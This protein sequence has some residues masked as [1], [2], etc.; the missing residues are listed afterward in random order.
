MPRLVKPAPDSRLD[1]LHGAL[2][3]ND[4]TDPVGRDIDLPGEAV[5]L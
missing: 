1:L 5:L 2:T 3:G 4:L